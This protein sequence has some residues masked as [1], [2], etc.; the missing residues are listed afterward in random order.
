MGSP[1][2]LSEKCG[3][4]LETQLL[5]SLG[6]ISRRAKALLGRA[7][8]KVHWTLWHPSRALLDNKKDFRMGSPFLLFEKCGALLETQLLGSLGSIS[9][10]AKA[11]LGRASAKVHR[12]LWHP[13]RAL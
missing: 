7:R 3:A 4:L 8:A 5:G 9:R 13:S 12:T 2:L 11:P 10:D 6:S 1:F